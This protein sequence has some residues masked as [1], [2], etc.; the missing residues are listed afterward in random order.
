MGSS[1]LPLWGR[2]GCDGVG[3]SVQWV[4]VLVVAVVVVVVVVVLWWWWWCSGG[5]GV[6][7]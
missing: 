5:V 6:V 1:G 7:V 3:D 2:V 4:G